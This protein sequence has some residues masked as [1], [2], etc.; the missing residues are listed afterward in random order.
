MA[1]NTGRVSTWWGNVLVGKILT[2]IGLVLFLAGTV[3]AMVEVFRRYVF[4]VSFMW[5]QDMVVVSLLCGISLY[6]TVSQWERS[7]I[8]VTA[9]AEFIARKKSPARIRA[10]QIINAVADAWTGVFISLLFI[11]GLP[12]VFDYKRLGI[13]LQSQVIEFWPFFLVFVLALAPLALTYFLHAYQG[14]RR[15]DLGGPDDEEVSK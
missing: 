3:L 1:H 5:Q 11:W 2:P 14:F 13:R 7:H 4:G 8:S 12:L 6:F 9:V 15:S 10:V